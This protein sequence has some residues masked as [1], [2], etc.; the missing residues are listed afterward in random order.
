M[1][2]LDD[3]GLAAQTALHHVGVDGALCKE[4]HLADLLGLF[5]EHADELFADDLALALRLGDALQLAEVAVAG[6][7]TD[8][9]DVEAIGIARAKDRADL[10]LFVLT[11]Q[12]VI[13]EHAG[14]LL[15][16]GLGQHS[17]QHGG[18]HAA[19]QCAQHLALA[20]ALPQSLD[21]VLYKGIHL[22][23]A[24]AAADVV[25]EVA[26]HLLALGG[27]QHLRV[28]LYGVQTLFGIFNGCHRA[29]CGVGSDLEAG[30]RL[31]DVV[32]VAHPADGRR[33]HIGEQLALGVHKHLGLAVLTLGSA[34]DMTA[35]QVHHQLAAVA[36]AQHRHA[37]AED[38]G[39]DGGRIL[40]INAVGAA[41]EDNALG[42]L[43]LDDRKIGF[44]GIDL[45]VDIIFS[46][47]AGNQLIVLSA[48]VQ[49][50]DSFMLHDVFLHF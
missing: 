25:H 38:L 17:G 8:E 2:T 21:I 5:L 44:I 3:G 33:L 46:D 22:P 4:V 20:D 6:I 39:V 37:P 28:E 23:V 7:H 18:I 11:Q 41:G 24:G 9:V 47:A 16:D 14:Q 30:S 26:Q 19:G 49:H 15:A 34:A 36:D 12:T 48:K 42:I 32:I 40:Q 27:V 35:Q 13:H 31:L 50:D 10:F 45:A 43:G 29:V 1:V